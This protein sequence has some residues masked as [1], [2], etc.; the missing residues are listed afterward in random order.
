MDRAGSSG[1]PSGAI[2]VGRRFR[3]E[4]QMASL[5]VRMW[6]AAWR[7]VACSKRCRGKERSPAGGQAA[8]PVEKQELEVTLSVR[9]LTPDQGGR[10]VGCRC[11]WG[12]LSLIPGED[13][14]CLPAVRTRAADLAAVGG[15]RALAGRR[16]QGASHRRSYDRS[17]RDPP[18]PGPW[19]GLSQGR[20]GG[21]QWERRTAARTT[22]RQRSEIL[23]VSLG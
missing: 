5:L 1:E 23:G 13:A 2:G 15:E 17:L 22:T 4:P 14:W 8:L 7:R 20:L 18:R 3:R 11:P 10:A 21:S 9:R 6:I 16:S 12:R 19:K